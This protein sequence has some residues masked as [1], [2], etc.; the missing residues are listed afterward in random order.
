M[1]GEDTSSQ[2]PICMHTKPEYFRDPT[3]TNFHPCFVCKI[4]IM[5]GYIFED[6]AKERGYVVPSTYDIP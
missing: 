6:I 4:G 5:G 3:P 1:C 2:L